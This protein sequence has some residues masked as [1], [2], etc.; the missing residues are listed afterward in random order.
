[1]LFALVVIAGATKWLPQGDA[2]IDHIIVPIIAFPAVWVAF[3]LTLYGAR[4]P[5]RAWA[6]IC[7]VVAVHLVLIVLGFSGGAAS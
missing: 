1:M 4:R 6:A 7:A 3:A 2:G 5:A